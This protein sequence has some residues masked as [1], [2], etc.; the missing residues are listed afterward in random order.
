MLVECLSPVDIERPNG[1]HLR[2]HTVPDLDLQGSVP[3]DKLEQQLKR[4]HRAAC[5]LDAD[6]IFPAR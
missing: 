1:S 5:R 6:A 3:E 2:P 4:T